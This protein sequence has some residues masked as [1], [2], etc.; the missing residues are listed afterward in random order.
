[1]KAQT[2]REYQGDS[3]HPGISGDGRFVIFERSNAVVLHDRTT[4]VTTILGEG[5]QPF[6]TENGRVAVFAAAGFD[7]VAGDDVNGQYRDIYSVDLAG[8]Q[9]HR[10]SVGMQGLDAQMASSSRTEREQRRP[11]CGIFIEASAL[12]RPGRFTVRLRARYGTSDHQA[13]RRWMES[14]AERRWTLRRI[15]RTRLTGFR[16]SL[17]QT[18][19]PARRRI[20]TKSV[21][22]GLANGNSARPVMSSNGR[23][24]A[25]QSEA[26][27][28]VA[29]EDFNL[30]WDVF[31]LDRTTNAI[32]RLSGDGEEA[33]MEPSSGPSIDATGSVVAFSSRHPTDAS[34]KRND[35]DL[36][37]ATIQANTHGGTRPTGDHADQKGIRD[38]Q[39][40]T[41]ISGPSFVADAALTFDSL[42]PMTASTAIEPYAPSTND[43]AIESPQLL[44]YE[45]SLPSSNRAGAIHTFQSPVR[46]LDGLELRIE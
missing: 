26:S 4:D 8:G 19:T 37:V 22:R 39:H 11:I 16:T 42:P 5:Y 34:D 18:C 15:R 44:G 30:L 2:L 20:I 35:F 41:E 32:T 28:L 21:R 38:R 25:F 7:R 1:M 46:A 14:F 31:V 3:S 40:D 12:R 29:V 6:I 27:D 24:V 33:W 9:A 43:A 10:V 13:D 23:F 36:Y 45:R 17:S